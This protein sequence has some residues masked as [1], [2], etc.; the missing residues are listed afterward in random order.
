[1]DKFTVSAESFPS[2]YSQIQCESSLMC[3]WIGLVTVTWLCFT[4]YIIL[5]YTFPLCCST[6]CGTQ[7]Y[8]VP[9]LKIQNKQNIKPWDFFSCQVSQLFCFW[10]SG[11][12]P[13]LHP[14]I[15]TYW[16]GWSLTTTKNSRCHF[17]FVI[18]GVHNSRTHQLDFHGICHQPLLW[19]QHI[20]YI[21][22]SRPISWSGQLW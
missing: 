7:L 5:G 18:S 22:R 3:F 8:N 19:D 9:S 20:S 6:V 10:E 13:I 14:R 1:M 16:Y 15:G 12:L 21:A 17:I 2:R 4:V 11:W